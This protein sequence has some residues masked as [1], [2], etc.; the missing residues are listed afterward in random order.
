M[1][2]TARQPIV[3]GGFLAAAL[4]DYVGDGSSQKT[5]TKRWIW[6]CAGFLLLPVIGFRTVKEL[7]W[8]SWLGFLCTVFVAAVCVILPLVSFSSVRDD[9]MASSNVTSIS[10]KTIDYSNFAAAF[11]SITVS[12]GGHATM[13]NLVG[14]MQNPDEFPTA[15][16]LTYLAIVLLYFPVAAVG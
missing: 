3:A 10:H 12:M 9:A 11:A 15:I 2:N 14:H 16:N 1:S 4:E 8:M 6:A 5:W 7:S 13:P